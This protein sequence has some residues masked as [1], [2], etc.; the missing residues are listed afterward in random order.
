MKGKHRPVTALALGISCY[1]AFPALPFCLSLSFALPVIPVYGAPAR[2]EDEIDSRLK[3]A[4]LLTID[5]KYREA[6][7]NYL[8][9]FEHSRGLQK[10]QGM[11]NALVSTELVKLA[12]VYEPAKAEVLKLRDDREKLILENKAKCADVQDWAILNHNLQDDRRSVSIYKQLS[13]KGQSTDQICDWIEDC[14]PVSLVR[15]R[16]YKELLPWAQ[17]AAADYIKTVEESEKNGFTGRLALP[18][19]MEDVYASYEVLLA[20]GKEDEADKLVQVMLR[21]W[22]SHDMFSAFVRAAR[23]TNHTK[24]SEDLLAMAKK[25]VSATDYELIMGDLRQSGAAH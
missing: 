15:A 1:F 11:R 22:S 23:R 14:I 18:L 7:D 24:V 13:A 2:G 21:P 9:I 8:W 19:V 25:K 17:R 16:E 10:W 5:K 12:D 3:N 20:D 6:L 4:R